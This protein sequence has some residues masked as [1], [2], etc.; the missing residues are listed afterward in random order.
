MNNQMAKV[1]H[2]SWSDL[3]TLS[4]SLADSIRQAHPKIDV[5][6]GV[7]RGGCFPAL[8]LSYLL[9]IRYLTTIQVSTTVSEAARAKRSLPQVSCIPREDDIRDK[10]CLLV[11]DVTNTGATLQIASEAILKLKPSQLIT[12]ALVWDTVSANRDEPRLT[13]CFSEFIASEIHAWASFPWLAEND[14]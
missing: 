14:H 3:Q 6:I 7:A 4:K 12:A 8:L 11:D 9:G 13:K 5:I 2:Y 1:H 10:R